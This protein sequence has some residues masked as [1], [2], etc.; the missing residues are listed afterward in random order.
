M[1]KHPNHIYIQSILGTRAQLP[2]DIIPINF[3]ELIFHVANSTAYGR[4]LL[5]FP[6]TVDSQIF[7]SNIL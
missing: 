2:I 7:M 4:A 3:S 1:N 6:F 5:T